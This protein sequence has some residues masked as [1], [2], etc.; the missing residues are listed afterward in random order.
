MRRDIFAIAVAGTI[1]AS[2]ASSGS[3]GSTNGGDAPPPA[4]SVQQSATA[5]RTGG[6]VITAEQIAKTNAR[7]AYEAILRTR[8]QLLRG[9]GAENPTSGDDSG[10]LPAVYLNDVSFGS[11]G[12]LRQIPAASIAEIRFISASDAT[13]RWGTGHAYGVINVLT[14]Q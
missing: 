1:A 13:T 5:P 3:T 8:P 11:I 2:C 9:K 4:A 14:K 12:M 10:T 7:D 6:M